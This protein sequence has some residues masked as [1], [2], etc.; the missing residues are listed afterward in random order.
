VARKPICQIAGA[1]VVGRAMLGKKTCPY[2]F[3]NSHTLPSPLK[4]GGFMLCN[5][6][7]IMDDMV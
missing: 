6:Q 7:S 1:N 4:F 3:V 5:V 2:T